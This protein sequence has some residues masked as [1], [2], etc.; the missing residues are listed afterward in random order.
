MNMNRHSLVWALALPLCS[1]LLSGLSV[2]H[3]AD[4]RMTMTL[5]S[6]PPLREEA[7]VAPVEFVE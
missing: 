3:A 4:G 1:P 5:A 2:A 7:L 6:L